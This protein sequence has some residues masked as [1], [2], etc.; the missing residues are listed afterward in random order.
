[1]IISGEH[2]TVKPEPAIFK[3]ALNRIGRVA[4]E[5]VFIDDSLPNIETARAI[6]F[7]AIHFSSPT[8]LKAELANLAIKGI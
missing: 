6:G 7:H 4:E 2:K 3:L 5:C 8:Q 1:M